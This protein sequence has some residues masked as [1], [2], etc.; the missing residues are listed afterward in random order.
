MLSFW[1]PHLRDHLPNGEVIADHFL[2][3]GKRA[4]AAL[5]PHKCLVCGSYINSPETCQAMFESSVES[6]FETCLGNLICKSCL[7]KGFNPVKSPLCTRCGKPFLSS[8]G[9]D[10]LCY[11][12][13]K[14]RDRLGKVRAFGLYDSLLRECIHMFK[15]QGKVSL[16]R[17]LGRLMFQTFKSHFVAQPV[18]LIFP[19]PLHK[20]R[21]MHRGFNQAYLLVR[22][23]PRLWSLWAGFPPPWTISNSLLFRSKNTASQTGFDKARRIE[24]IRGAFMV[25]RPAEIM[26]KR[27]VLIDDV[28]TTGATAREA[29]LTLYGAGAMSVD[30]LVL[31]RV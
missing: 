21:L 28:Y 14:A 13:I 12:C 16:A 23:F 7:K 5:F 11:E 26:G 18:D 4:L 2:Y 25:K 8:T 1:K 6:L 29:A 31:A 10:H 22:D 15:Y 20:R 9:P 30:L 27:I 19:V 17:P 24:N 3:V